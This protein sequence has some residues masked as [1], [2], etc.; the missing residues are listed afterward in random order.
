MIMLRK[1]S[2]E[3]MVN[4]SIYCMDGQGG[5]N[6]DYQKKHDSKNNSINVFQERQNKGNWNV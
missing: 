6:K 4:N 2:Y 3:L 5:K 1:K